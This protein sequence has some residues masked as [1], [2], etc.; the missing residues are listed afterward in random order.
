[1]AL[2]NLTASSPL[3]LATP[4]QGI[5]LIPADTPLTRL[6]YFDGKFLRAD[7]LLAEQRYLRGLVALSNQAGGA[8]IVHGLDVALDGGDQLSLSPGLAIDPQGR[9]LLLPAL[10]RLS[11]AL[12]V[13]RSRT[14]VGA[15]A[16][17]A[18]G[19]G[20]FAPCEVAVADAPAPLPGRS[21]YLVLLSHAE[22]LCGEEDVVGMLCADACAGSTQRPW[23]IEGVRL[24]L[25][26]LA[27]ASALPASSAVT[28]GPRHLR[29]QIASAYF[30]DEA[31]AVGSLVSG[32]GLH[33]D[34]W[35]HGAAA[36][37]GSEV[38]L[39]VLVR[40]GNA[41]RFVD[42]WTARRERIAL[43]PQR[44][45]QQR[46]AMR[47]MD[48][49]LAQVLQFQCQLRDVLAG[50]VDN[51][52]GGQDNPCT[53]AKRLVGEA[54][55][56]VALITRIY[57]ATAS[58]LAEATRSVREGVLAAEPEFQKHLADL[59]GFG[60]RLDA[61]SASFAAQPSAQV[62]IDGGIVELP[63]AGWLPV[64]PGDSL[65]VNAQVRRLLGDGVDLRFCTAR[66]DFL[67]HAW[68]EAQ[69]MDRISLLE[70]LDHADR[71]PQVDILVPDGRIAP[72]RD[73]TGRYYDMRINLP[74]ANL[75]DLVTAVGHALE[76]RRALRSQR[77]VKVNA[78]DAARAAKAFATTAA[79][80]AEAAA[81][82]AST[83][84]LSQ[85]LEVNGAARGEALPGRGIAF[86]FAGLTDNFATLQTAR[87]V[88][89]QAAV[90]TVAA[91]TAAAAPTAASAQA[92]EGSGT[93]PLPLLRAALWCSLQ[94]ER[95]PTTLQ[96]GAQVA[97]GAE[98]Y[99][100]VLV[101]TKAGSPSKSA[102]GGA[103]TTTPTL[104]RAAFSGSLRI[105][106]IEARP[107]AQASVLAEGELAGE[108]SA[109]AVSDGDQIPFVLHLSEAVQVSRSVGAA[110]PE[111]RLAALAPTLAAPEVEELT[112]ERSWRSAT[113]AE[114]ISR[115]RLQVSGASDGD[116]VG[117][118]AARALLRQLFRAWQQVNAAVAEPAHPAHEHAIRALRAIGTALDGG[119]FAD[120]KAAQL[121]PPA[122]APTSALTLLAVRDW[123]LFHRRRDKQCQP[124]AAAQAPATRGYALHQVAVA[125]A[126]ELDALQKAFAGN[127]SARLAKFSFD[128]LQVVDF[129]AGVQS[130]LS[131][132]AQVR[133]SWRQDVGSAAGTIVGG[134]IASRGA[135]LAEGKALAAERAAALT[136]LLDAEFAVATPT[137]MA[138]AT[139]LPDAFADGQNDG[140]ILLATLKQA[141]QCQSAYA[142]Q[143]GE[144]LQFVL[145][146]A[147]QGELAAALANSKLVMALGQ[148][149]FVGSRP[150]A[151][152]IAALKTAWPANL[153][154]VSAATVIGLKGDTA[155]ATYLAQAGA[156]AQALG[157]AAVPAQAESATAPPQ[158]PAITVF[159]GTVLRRN[160][161]LVYSNWDSPNHFLQE[162]APSSPMEFRNNLAQGSALANFVAALTANQP[163]LGV[164][165]ATTRAA[166]DGD[167][168]GRLA[169]VVAALVAANRPAPT[170]RRQVVQAINEHDRSEVQRVL[171]IDPNGFDEVIFLE[172]NAG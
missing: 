62:L 104:L 122:P 15:A 31:A 10:Q 23:R 61:A 64:V 162:N 111:Y 88:L 57:H 106:R 14:T 118:T 16:A 20:Q 28:L 58:R 56:Q 110:G 97:V 114:C 4:G 130:V 17:S 103:S 98:V 36:F 135:A 141:T 109:S 41:T 168:A 143:T 142:V 77:I 47:P 107:G 89:H 21:G 40:E 157:L 101:P 68:E 43:P 90:A 120:I 99:L 146:L 91:A 78:V 13:E 113:Q 169:Q 172:L 152:D 39:G 123:V 2:Q 5:T 147:A 67:A 161:L 167:A 164:T 80:A 25:A 11:V 160:A 105:D 81:P 19:V 24:R 30:A 140:V 1:M 63:A 50:L 34:I 37:G 3:V 32:V 54:Q 119:R 83:K 29:S 52:G 48:V 151:E 144:E 18:G 33:S 59:A 45:W 136:D 86:H 127:D 150:Q 155:A 12:L 27:L 38:A 22:A 79:G 76:R 139:R 82:R 153:G 84:P 71:K 128:F 53:Q 125:S 44:Y 138:V 70:G 156:M 6:N 93:A 115:M 148:V 92:T 131:P 145:R 95:D 163:V 26:P 159:A 72:G 9:V 126:A 170:A 85:T 134:C 100:L 66:P 158:C 87:A 60:A 102:A 8:G 129:A 137:D 117:T 149:D 132:P 165:L 7:D 96:R 154:A 42:A 116:S 65:D 166:P 112:V 133:A 55:A 94:I 108:L 35:C 49:Y 73:A 46:M 171:Q 69:H 75:E 51:G 74:L 121:F 124:V